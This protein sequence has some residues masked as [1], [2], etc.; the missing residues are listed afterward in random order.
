MSEREWENQELNEAR[1]RYLD[2]PRLDLSECALCGARAVKVDPARLSKAR[3]HFECG[4]TIEFR[5]VAS[6]EGV[7]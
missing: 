2:P 7:T 5:M 1:D 6:C 4:L 3:V